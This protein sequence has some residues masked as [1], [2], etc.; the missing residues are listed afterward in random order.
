[1]YIHTYPRP[2][3]RGMY[4]PFTAVLND[5]NTG[6]N[7]VP[8]GLH[9]FRLS[10]PAAHRKCRNRLSGKGF[11]SQPLGRSF[12]LAGR[13]GMYYVC[14]MISGLY[15]RVSNLKTLK[16]L[17]FSNHVAF[18]LHKGPVRRMRSITMIEPVA[19]GLVGWRL[20]CPPPR[21]GRTGLARPSWPAAEADTSCAFAAERRPPPGAPEVHNIRVPTQTIRFPKDRPAEIFLKFAKEVTHARSR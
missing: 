13:A 4:I 18:M 17:A 19:T 14:S 3:R 10:H 11:S 7:P 1:M 9:W 6:R 15:I 21:Q 12:L 20:S 16:S 8:V 2:W 5:T